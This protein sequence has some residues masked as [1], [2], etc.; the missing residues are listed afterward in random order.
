M[1]AQE[2]A[3]FR[4]NVPSHVREH[5]AS[6]VNVVGDGNCGFRAVALAITNDENNW[7]SI[8]QK[9]SETMSNSKEIFTTYAC[10]KDENTY[11]EVLKS[12]DW[13]TGSCLGEGKYYMV[14]PYTGTITF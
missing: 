6:Y 2:V 12:F 10:Y 11:E 8:R 14:M 1:S 7:S 3:T 5:I 4:K 13:K 9:L